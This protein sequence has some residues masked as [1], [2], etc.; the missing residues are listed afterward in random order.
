MLER[1]LQDLVG[2]GRRQRGV[3]VAVGRRRT[4]E[5]VVVVH[6]LAEREVPRGRA[7]GITHDVR[8]LLHD[9]GRRNPGLDRV[10]ARGADQVVELARGRGRALRLA[11]A[12]VDAPAADPGRG[13]RERQVERRL[14]ARG[15]VGDRARAGL[16]FIERDR[17][18]VEAVAAAR[19]G[20]VI[21]RERLRDHEAWID[22]RERHA[23]GEVLDRRLHDARG[24]RAVGPAVVELVAQAHDESRLVGRVE[25]DLCAH[26]RVGDIDVAL[27]E[28]WRLRG[29]RARRM[30]ARAVLGQQRI[31]RRC[32]KRGIRRE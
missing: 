19:D 18:I 25:I 14:D 7:A 8:H 10:F 15:V 28:E 1:R 24:L 29:S 20:A 32:E 12:E 21:E 31:D 3:A 17:G 11:A 23:V 30:A 22:L 13:A 4:V 2:R 5:V 27:G 16:E 6:R 26:G 9:I